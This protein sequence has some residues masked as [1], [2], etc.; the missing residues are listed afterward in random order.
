M[1][2]YDDLSPRMRAVREGASRDVLAA[3]DAGDT[4]RAYGLAL[5]GGLA[6]GAAFSA[7]M[8]ES[9]RE[10]FANTVGPA[11]D[12]AG[13]FAGGLFG[14]DDN[15]FNNGGR[16]R[17]PAPQPSGPTPEEAR[18]NPPPAAPTP[19]APAAA[20]EPD[21]ARFPYGLDLNRLQAMFPQAS[22]K[23]VPAALRNGLALRE[24]AREQLAA[25]GQAPRA[26]SAPKRQS[27]EDLQGATESVLRALALQPSSGRGGFADLM[28][29]RL[30]L[31]NAGQQLVPIAAERARRSRAYDDATDRF[32]TEQELGLKLG[33]LELGRDKLGLQRDALDYEILSDD[34]SYGLNRF[35]AQFG[36]IN[37]LLTLGANERA[38]RIKAALDA[39]EAFYDRVRKLQAADPETGANYDVLTF[40]GRGPDGRPRTIPL[41]G[42]EG[43]AVDDPF[44]EVY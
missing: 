5:R 14:V 32:K 12:A 39:D 15:P 41:G 1:A 20:P 9:A 23:A 37:D 13:R 27:D 7:D 29:Y 38:A 10:G 18:P 36:A 34:R 6:E 21:T 30:G 24:A 22:A 25:Q 16:G 3:E 17:A 44:R 19:R 31:L 11:L 26:P 28:G 35:N 33:D 42:A 8:A 2:R 4:A 43:P 40:L